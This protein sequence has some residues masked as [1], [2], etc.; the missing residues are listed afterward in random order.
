MIRDVIERFRYRFDLWCRE[1]REDSFWR[2][3]TDRESASRWDDPKYRVLVT[4]STSRFLLRSFGTYFGLLIIAVQICRLVGAFIPSIRFPLSVFFVVLWC[5]WTIIDVLSTI[6]LYKARKVHR[7]QLSKSSL[8]LTAA[9]QDDQVSI[10][11]PPF[12]PGIPPFRK[13]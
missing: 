4:E 8:Q 10:H 9:R 1:R 13:R 5:F 7:E 6:D 2:P 3:S 11:E 12:T